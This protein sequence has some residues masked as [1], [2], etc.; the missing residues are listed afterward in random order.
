VRG[1]SQGRDHNREAR[2]QMRKPA[3]VAAATALVL[4]ALPGY[5]GGNG[6]QTETIH[7]EDT[8]TFTVGPDCGLPEGTVAFIEV[9]GVMH[10]TERPNGQIHTNGTFVAHTLTLT[11]PDGKVFTGHFADHFATNL[12]NRNETATFTSNNIL[13]AADG[14]RLQLHFLDHFNLS[15]TGEPHFFFQLNCGGGDVNR[16]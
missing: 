14:S 9:S 12:N 6:A 16:D 1:S 7:F 2:L 5:A 10:T 13:R 8:D 15:A 4:F 3:L 11:L